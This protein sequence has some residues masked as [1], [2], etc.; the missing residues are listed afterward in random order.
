M[1]FHEHNVSTLPPA[2]LIGEQLFQAEDV[3]GV[4]VETRPKSDRISLWTKTTDKQRTMSLGRE[5]QNLLSSFL[6]G[7]QVCLFPTTFLSTP[8]GSQPRVVR[9]SIE[10][11]VG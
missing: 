3:C 10:I 9:Y 8:V 2:Q 7:D 6:P 11:N 4:A 5:L 1:L